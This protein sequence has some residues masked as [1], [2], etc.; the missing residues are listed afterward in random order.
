VPFK[1][2][3]DTFIIYREDQINRNINSHFGGSFGDESF[4]KVGILFRDSGI[5]WD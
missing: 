5:S 2:N 4:E 1:F 3:K